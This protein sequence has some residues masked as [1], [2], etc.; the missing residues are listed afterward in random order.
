MVTIFQ[1]IGISPSPNKLTIVV[2][3]VMGAAVA[4][5]PLGPNHEIVCNAYKYLK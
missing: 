3:A 4:E 5:A 2:V 1:Q